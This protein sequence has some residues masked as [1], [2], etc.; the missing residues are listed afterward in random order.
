M[1]SLKCH[2]PHKMYLHVHV[3][4]CT[5]HVAIN[6][7]MYGREGFKRCLCMTSWV[8][9]YSRGGYRWI[10]VQERSLVDT[11]H[12]WCSLWRVC[13]H[14]QNKI[15]LNAKCHQTKLQNFRNCVFSQFQQCRP[16]FVMTIALEDRCNLHGTTL[17]IELHTYTT[18]VDTR[19]WKNG[20]LE[21]ENMGNKN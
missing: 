9:P 8:P 5:L 21:Y 14:R 15:A 2:K 6:D 12:S 17:K 1:Q 3:S 4:T 19:Q 20:K 11:K 10:T 18:N 16:C 7:D 13:V